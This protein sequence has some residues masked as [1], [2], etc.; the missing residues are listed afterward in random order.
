MTNHMPCDAYILCSNPRSGTTLL[1]DLLRQ[2]GVAGAPESY[3]RQKSLADWCRSWDIPGEVKLTDAVFSHSYL[4]AMMQAGRAGTPPFGLRL[5]GPDLSFACDWL[6][7]VHPAASTD[8]QRFEAAF[9]TTRYIHLSRTDKLAE[10]VSYLRA[11]QTGLW[12]GTPAG[13]DIERIAPTEPDGYDAARITQRV[14]MLRA[15][16]EAW[17]QWFKAEDITPLRITYEALSSDALEVLRK[18]LIHI[19]K[20]ADTA[21][22]VTPGTRKLADETSAAWIARYRQT[23]LS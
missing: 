3:F 23:H 19:G 9:G 20:N 2:T 7:R 12:H 22:H 5:M 6:G 11:E 14:E 4:S 16:D 8:H 1:C 21:D 18:V 17:E 13:D 10:A 15:Y